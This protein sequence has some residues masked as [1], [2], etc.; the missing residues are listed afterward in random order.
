MHGNP[1]VL[2]FNRKILKFIVLMTC[3]LSIDQPNQSLGLEP[4]FLLVR[5]CPILVN[6]GSEE[7][8]ARSVACPRVRSARAARRRHD[9]VP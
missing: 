1:D 2:R 5:S 9:E 7:T 8:S 3:G 4:S 6:P